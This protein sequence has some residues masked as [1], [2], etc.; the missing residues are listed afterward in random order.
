MSFPSPFLL[1]IISPGM[2]RSLLL[3]PRCPTIVYHQIIT[4][5]QTCRHKIKPVLNVGV[6]V[7]TNFEKF[8]FHQPERL[9]QIEVTNPPLFSLSIKTY[10]NFLSNLLCLLKR[11]IDPRTNVEPTSTVF[12]KPQSKK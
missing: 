8:V 5:S 7:S 3:L 9:M 1:F 12:A 10:C 2:D 6:L 4:L 11:T